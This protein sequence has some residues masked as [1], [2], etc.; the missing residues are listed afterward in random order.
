MKKGTI[1]LTMIVLLASCS[2]EDAPEL[3][4]HQ[5]VD[6]PA[7]ANDLESTPRSTVSEAGNSV[8]NNPFVKPADASAGEAIENTAAEYADDDYTSDQPDG[9]LAFAESGYMEWQAP[10]DVAYSKAEL[11]VTGANGERLHR[12]FV[13]GEAIVIQDSIPDGHY[14]WESVVT[15]EIDP[16]V[17]EQMR[18]VRES[19]NFDAEQALIA[20]LRAE[21]SL[22]TASQAQENRKS[23]SFSVRDG[24]AT[25]ITP[26]YVDDEPQRDG[27]G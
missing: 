24:V 21:G 20:K 5:K 16:Y 6:N 27:Q 25:P 11:V 2:G 14:L 26:T 12:S 10:A 15:P 8:N 7:A 3:V 13:P 19:G 18:E 17:K 9:G 22:P 1:V 4:S 23:G